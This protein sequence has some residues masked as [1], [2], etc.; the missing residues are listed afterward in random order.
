MPTA[1][2]TRIARLQTDWPAAEAAPYP[3]PADVEAQ[4]EAAG[5]AR[6]TQWPPAAG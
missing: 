3:V 2:E 1:A 5:R 4:I 6:D